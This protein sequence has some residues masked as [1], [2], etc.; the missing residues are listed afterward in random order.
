M[1]LADCAMSVSGSVS[2]ELLYHTTP[3][4]ILYWIDRFAYFV[5]GFFRKVK[6]I[7]L[8]NLLAAGGLE[9]GREESREQRAEGEGRKAEGGA[10]RDRGSGFRVQDSDSVRHPS[11]VIPHPSS[12]LFPEY[13]TCEDKSAEIAAHIV[14]WLQ[15]PACAGGAVEALAALKKHAWRTAAPR[16]RPPTIFSTK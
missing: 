7:T 2:L 11:S 16:P 12:A 3:T 6:Y 1:R 9:E 15:D 8:V 13:L 14:E 10:W 5:Q 4:V